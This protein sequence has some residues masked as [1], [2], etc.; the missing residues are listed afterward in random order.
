[1]DIR[2]LKA[3]TL[4]FEERNITQAALRAHISQPALSANIRQLEEALGAT[5]FR[6][7]AKGVEVTEAA[8][9]LY[10][11]AL[12]LVEEM[13]SLTEIFRETAGPPFVLGVMP[14]TGHSALAGFLR[15]SRELSPG[16]IF[17]LTSWEQPQEGGMALHARF[18]L[19]TLRR[20]DELFL[21]ACEDEYL[22][23]L[24]PDHPLALKDR[25]H[26]DD[27]DGVDFI[28]CPPCEAHQQTLGLCSGGRGLPRVAAQADQKSQ[29]AALALAG[30]GVTFLPQSL[31]E[32]TPG[33][34]TRPFAG[35]RF[36]RRMGLC[37]TVGSAG[38]PLIAAWQAHLNER[39]ADAPVP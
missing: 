11:K 25:I 16:V 29:V 5:L 7:G 1:M 9:Q 20:E 35:P 3:F 8:R 6:R 33:L 38:H 22:F 31:L 17:H 2:L 24:R 13:G 34:V 28:I 30:V 39:P 19:D 4:V 12:R 32:E 26:P 21:C 15:K 18:A 14:D 10:P 37:C 36:F 23:C 27:L